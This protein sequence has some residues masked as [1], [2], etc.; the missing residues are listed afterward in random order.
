MKRLIKLLLPPLIAT[1]IELTLTLDSIPH[2][3]PLIEFFIIFSGILLIP[4]LTPIFYG[5]ILGN[6][7]I[8]FLIGFSSAAIGYCFV[9]QLLAL[10]KFGVVGVAN[11]FILGVSSVV[12]GGLC[13]LSGYFAAKKYLFSVVSWF[14]KFLYDLYFWKWFF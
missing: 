3:N 4:I 9:P 7:N 10:Y 5:Y 12:I 8:S 1:V 2:R 11:L 6:E 14:D 13:G